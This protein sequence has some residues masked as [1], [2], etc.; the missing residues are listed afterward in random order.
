[1]SDRLDPQDVELIATRALSLLRGSTEPSV[2]LVDAKTL[3]ELLGV[4]RAHGSTRTRRSFTPCALA[5]HTVG[6]GSTSAAS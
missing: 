2:R 5:V 6:S 4:A 1:M 3:P